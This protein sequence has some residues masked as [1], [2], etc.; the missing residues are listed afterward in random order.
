MEELI[1]SL[2]PV[3]QSILNIPVGWGQACS[4]THTHT[5][6]YTHTHTLSLSLA[7]LLISHSLYLFINN[8][9]SIYKYI[10]VL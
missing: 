10:V 5:Y 3:L 4:H 1:T 8:Y 2:L 7:L 9:I 6:T